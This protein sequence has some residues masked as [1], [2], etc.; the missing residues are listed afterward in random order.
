MHTHG[1][2]E[3]CHHVLVPEEPVVGPLPEGQRAVVGRQVLSLQ[4][5]R[6]VNISAKIE[7][8]AIV[9]LVEHFEQLVKNAALISLF[10]SVIPA[11]LAL[12]CQIEKL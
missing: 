10:V 8:L 6:D 12:D 1:L 9:G 3:V 2:H 5:A 11:V 4:G 7:R